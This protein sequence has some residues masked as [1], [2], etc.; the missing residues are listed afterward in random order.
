[1]ITPAIRSYA[2][3]AD[4]YAFSLVDTQIDPGVTS[5]DMD[6][7]GE[8]DRFLTWILPF[9]D[10]VGMLGQ[11]GISNFDR[12][13]HLQFLVATSTQPNSFNQDI[14][15][16]GSSITSTE[17]WENLGG[18]SETYTPSSLMPVPEPSA[19]ALL[20]AGMGFAMLLFLQRRQAR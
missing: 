12:D 18:F 14:N 9:S 11:A 5:L 6:L 2:P 15:G 8:Q 17:T 3:T 19:G 10:V 16:L 13:T 4:N 7:G 20:C 1:M